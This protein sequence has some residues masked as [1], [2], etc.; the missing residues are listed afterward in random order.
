MSIDTKVDQKSNT[1]IRTVTG[2]LTVADVKQAFAASLSHPDFKT[3]MHVIWDLN[4][5]DGSNLSTN[6][7][8]E[9]V[10]YIRNNSNVRGANYKIIL[11]APADLSFGLSRMFEGYGN[12][13]PEPIHVLRN[14][15]EAYRWIEDRMDSE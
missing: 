3:N 8:I 13:L 6:Q 4:Q 1:I 9:V 12:N 10:E 11:V 5:A 14:M 2:K 7:L 15:D